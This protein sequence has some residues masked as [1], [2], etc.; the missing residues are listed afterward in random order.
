MLVS[1]HVQSTHQFQEVLEL[2]FEILWVSLKNIC[3]K[4]NVPKDI[5]KYQPKVIAFEVDRY[6]LDTLPE[7]IR[8]TKGNIFIITWDKLDTR[9]KSWYLL[10]CSSS[11]EV[12]AKKTK[13]I[14]K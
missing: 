12:L 10:N 2:F 8:C 4:V 5:M 7:M 14:S 11:F 6:I 9:S 1:I 3:D 13:K